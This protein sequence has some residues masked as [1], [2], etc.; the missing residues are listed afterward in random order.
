MDRKIH[1]KSIFFFCSLR[2]TCCIF[3]LLLSLCSLYNDF[4]AHAKVGN[5]KKYQKLFLVNVL[6]L[7]I[8]PQSTLYPWFMDEG[9]LIRFIYLPENCLKF[10]W[11]FF[12]VSKIIFHF[13]VFLQN[14]TNSIMNI[15]KPHG[16]V[17]SK[18]TCNFVKL[19]LIKYSNKSSTYWVYVVCIYNRFIVG[20]KKFY[21]ECL[22]GRFISV[23]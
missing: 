4:K 3:D 17:A 5:G 22:N 13:L 2:L 15:T 9:L 12:F 1:W 19:F 16:L 14:T 21:W 8:R 18:C 23:V 6:F 7:Q 20:K 11:K 10:F